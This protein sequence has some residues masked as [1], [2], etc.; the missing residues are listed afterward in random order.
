MTKTE[1]FCKAKSMSGLKMN[2]AV[3]VGVLPLHHL[4]GH[5]MLFVI[6]DSTHNNA[7]YTQHMLAFI[8][9]LYCE[10][11]HIIRATQSLHSQGL[12]GYVINC[13]LIV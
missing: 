3:V 13:Q 6:T 7:A 10:S 2:T 8:N 9:V 4:M 1:Q 11:Q 5:M 12:V